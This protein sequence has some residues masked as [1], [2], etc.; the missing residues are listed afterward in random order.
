MKARQILAP[1]QNFLNS[2][3]VPVTIKYMVKLLVSFLLISSAFGD[4]TSDRLLKSLV[5]YY[6]SVFSQ[7][8]DT[9]ERKGDCRLQKT[10]FEIPTQDIKNDMFKLGPIGSVLWNGYIKYNINFDENYPKDVNRRNKFEEAMVK[11]FP[12][13]GEVAYKMAYL[14]NIKSRQFAPN[15]LNLKKF[16][17]SSYAHQDAFRHAYWSALMTKH[18]GEDFAIIFSAAHEINR[19]QMNRP[20]A[21]KYNSD[22]MMDHINN[23]KG[24]I[25]GSKYKNLSDDEIANVIARDI[26]NGKFYILDGSVP[27]PYYQRPIISSDN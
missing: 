14:A 7:V 24:R 19:E 22:E 20:I 15:F 17:S 8:R 9:L 11:K 12:K 18:L 6:S 25:Y 16:F 1:P 10:S 2:A 23:E 13:A 5:P 4:N 21:N 3:S 26:K 27:G